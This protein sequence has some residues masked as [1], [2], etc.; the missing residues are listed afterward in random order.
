MTSLSEGPI[1]FE[2]YPDTTIS[3]NDLNIL[4]SIV[5]EIKIHNYKMKQGSIS[6]ALIYK[7]H[8]KAMNS[9]FGTKYKLQPKKGETR[10]LQTDLT[11]TNTVIPK[12]I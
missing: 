9:A 12:T 4:D 7:I 5:L 6:I 2:V 10:F 3:F 1:S 8:Y 11:K